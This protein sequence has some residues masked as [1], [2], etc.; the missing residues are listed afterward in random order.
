MCKH[1]V[2]MSSQ[3]CL[4]VIGD[5]FSSCNL[6]LY[7]LTTESPCKE[8]CQFFKIYASDQLIHFTSLTLSPDVFLPPCLDFCPAA[9]IFLLDYSA[10]FKKLSSE[11]SRIRLLM[12]F[13]IIEFTSL[14]IFSSL[15][16]SLLFKF[17]LQFC[18]TFG[19]LP[20]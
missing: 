19:I 9:G 13:F 6:R 4:K 11:N 3:G 2:I 15:T 1:F 17:F 8:I 7:F 16:F 10:L 18:S 20:N 5:F 14:Y 12:Q